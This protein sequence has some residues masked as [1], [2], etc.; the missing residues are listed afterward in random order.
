MNPQHMGT[1]H[2]AHEVTPEEPRSEPPDD[3]MHHGCDIVL[4]NLG[5][6]VLPTNRLHIPPYLHGVGPTARNVVTPTSHATSS[7]P[8][9]FDGPPDRTTT[10]TGFV[11]AGLS[12]TTLIRASGL[13][14]ADEDGRRET[15][16]PPR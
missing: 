14:V 8:A 4:R 12:A 13:A 6:R 7:L 16:R 2:A 10:G 5:G 15:S 1:K 9:P 3:I 11:P